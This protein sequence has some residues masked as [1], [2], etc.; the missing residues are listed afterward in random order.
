MI[1]LNPQLKGALWQWTMNSSGWRS[2]K[3]PYHW[4]QLKIVLV[5]HTTDM[6]LPK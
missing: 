3:P 6:L 4:E 1:Y 5:V 2:L